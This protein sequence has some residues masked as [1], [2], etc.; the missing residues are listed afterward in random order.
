M[1]KMFTIDLDL[2][3]NL[4]FHIQHLLWELY[5]LAE[6][7]DLSFY[8]RDSDRFIFFVQIE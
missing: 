3:F 7:R 8:N 1:D 2:W 5:I 6:L 4:I